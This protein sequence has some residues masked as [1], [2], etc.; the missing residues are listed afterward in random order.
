MKH[1]TKTFS[2]L[3]FDRKPQHSEIFLAGSTADGEGVAEGVT[4]EDKK[5]K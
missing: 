1:L 3:D 4:E 2:G 5:E